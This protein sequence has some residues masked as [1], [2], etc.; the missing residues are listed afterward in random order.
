MTEKSKI[1]SNVGLPK[2][3]LDPG[4][5]A[6][7][8]PLGEKIVNGGPQTPAMPPNGG[9]YVHFDDIVYH[10]DDVEVNKSGNCKWTDVADALQ[11]IKACRRAIDPV[12]SACREALEALKKQIASFLEV[13]SPVVLNC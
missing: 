1:T 12:P 5:A 4:E 11:H 10:L 3:E 2:G 8:G 9:W 13:D 6:E 7:C